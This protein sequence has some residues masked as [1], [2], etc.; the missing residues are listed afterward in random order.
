LA[1]LAAGGARLRVTAREGGLACLV[2]VWDA[3]S[4][5]P[6]ARGEQAKSGVR[7]RGS[8]REQ[9]RSDVLAAVRA[10]GRPLTRKE[11]LRAL[12]EAGARHGPG[13][14]AKA[15]ADL[16]ASRELVNRRDKRGYRLPEW[17]KRRPGLF[18]ED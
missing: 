13:T 6:T 11:V 7:N 17:I 1:A 15:L 16:T 4:A 14:V 9:C 8:L 5:V 18:E 10:A 2:Q 3:T 12:K